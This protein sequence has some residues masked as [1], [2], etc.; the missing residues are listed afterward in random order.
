[1]ITIK[2]E[3]LKFVCLDSYCR[4]T[5]SA[6]LKTQTGDL[7]TWY[8]KDVTLEDK[9]D[10]SV[11]ILNCSYSDIEGEPDFPVKIID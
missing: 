5:Y 6:N 11:N 9:G 4:A 3:K 1:M 10:L 2:R 7:V 8:F